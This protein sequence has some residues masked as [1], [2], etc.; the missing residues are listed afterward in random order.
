MMEIYFLFGGWSPHS[1]EL[2]MKIEES[3]QL[4][5]LP[6]RRSKGITRCG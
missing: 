2:A 4:S 3:R 1:V 6:D 5:V